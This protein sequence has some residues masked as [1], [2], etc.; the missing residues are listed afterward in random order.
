M[1]RVQTTH[2]AEAAVAAY[3]PRIVLKPRCSV[4]TTQHAEA[5]LAAYRPRIVQKPQAKKLS[6]SGS[7]VERRLHI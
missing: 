3:R 7:K 6:T 1:L 2:R 4:Q 5:A